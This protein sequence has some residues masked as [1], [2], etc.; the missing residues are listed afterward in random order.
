M[1]FFYII[2]ITNTTIKLFVYAY[3]KYTDIKALINTIQWY[4]V[5]DAFFSIL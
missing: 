3:T 5:S 2:K 1:M 4:Y